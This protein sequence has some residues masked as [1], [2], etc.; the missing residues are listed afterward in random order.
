MTEIAADFGIPNKTAELLDL[1]A[2][3]QITERAIDYLVS[4]LNIPLSSAAFGPVKI[5]LSFFFA[6]VVLG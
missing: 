4:F 2:N 5:I 3:C 1:V 6:R